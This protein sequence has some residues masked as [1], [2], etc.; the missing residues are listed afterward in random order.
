MARKPNTLKTITDLT[1]KQRLFVDT[2]VSNWG[3][4]TKQDVAMEVFDCKDRTNA[5]KYAYQ[6]LHPDKSPH[7]VR[8]LEMQLSKE[9]KKYENDKLRHYKT[10]ERLQKKAEDKKQFNASINAQFRAGQMAGLFVDKRE[11]NITG[12]EGMSRENLEKRLEELEDKI[13]ENKKIINITP[14]EVVEE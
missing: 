1:P 5:S 14:K 10:Y 12:I 7:V 6:L 11:V 3:E 9:L 4:K 8:Y 13:N 2:L